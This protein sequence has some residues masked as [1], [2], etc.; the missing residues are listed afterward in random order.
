MLII[1]SHSVHRCSTTASSVV[2]SLQC[3]ASCTRAGIA[4]AANVLGRFSHSPRTTHWHAA[5]LV[6]RYLKGTQDWRIT[7][8]RRRD[9]TLSAHSDADHGGDPTKWPRL[10]VG[11]CRKRAI[12]PECDTVVRYICSSSALHYILG[13]G[14]GGLQH[15]LGQV[16][17]SMMMCCC[18]WERGWVG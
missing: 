1:E 3:C 7:H 9:G 4:C 16:A 2:G 8:S 11:M 12:T 18:L 10:G 6:V 5:Q 15:A 13:G 14:G 17:K